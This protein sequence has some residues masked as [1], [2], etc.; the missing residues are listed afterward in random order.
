V[1][2]YLHDGAKG[3][4]NTKDNLQKGVLMQND[5]PANFIR[6]ALAP[7]TQGTADMTSGNDG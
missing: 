7:P 3:I 1:V 2:R 5:Y 4:I 6:S